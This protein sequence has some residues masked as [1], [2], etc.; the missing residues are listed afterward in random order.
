MQQK[1]RDDTH[2][3]FPLTSNY[4]ET[5]PREAAWLPRKAERSVENRDRISRNQADRPV[6]RPGIFD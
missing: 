6:C 2:W 1:H 3:A 5:A 4:S